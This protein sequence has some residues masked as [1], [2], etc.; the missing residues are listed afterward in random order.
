MIMKF[1]PKLK[2]I[3]MQD[4]K[5]PKLAS[6]TQTPI[7]LNLD[8]KS[9]QGFN[10]NLLGRMMTP[11]DYLEAYNLDPVNIREKI[12]SGDKDYSVMANLPPA[13]LYEDLDNYNPEKVLVGFMCGYFLVQAQFA[14]SL[15]QSWTFKKGKFDYNAFTR[16][17]F[18]VFKVDIKW[19]INHK[20]WHLLRNDSP[21]DPEPLEEGQL[22]EEPF[23]DNQVWAAV[24]AQEE[25]HHTEVIME[26]LC[27]EEEVEWMLQDTQRRMKWLSLEPDE[28]QLLDIINQQRLQSGQRCQRVA[29]FKAVLEVELTGTDG[30]PSEGDASNNDKGSHGNGQS[31]QPRVSKKK[32]TIKAVNHWLNTNVT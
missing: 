32:K 3:L 22:E 9:G 17:L 8:M 21:R 18:K 13:F 10:N 6:K 20:K 12:K 11:I 2:T 23:G 30:K 29:T 4:D 1:C 31:S 5:E 24:L 15:Q 19:I 14:I 28:W 27:D 16:T 26:D 7:N 25:Q